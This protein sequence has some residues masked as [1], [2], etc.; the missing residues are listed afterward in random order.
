MEARKLFYFMVYGK[1]CSF[2]QIVKINTNSKTLELMRISED[3]FEEVLRAPMTSPSL[4]F[5]ST[6]LITFSAFITV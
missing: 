5:S 3:I 4:V 1:M 2:R 6:C